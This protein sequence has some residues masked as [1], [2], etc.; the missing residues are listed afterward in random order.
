MNS[1]KMT[2][3][4]QPIT[5]ET[6]IAEYK[7]GNTTTAIFSNGTKI[8]SYEGTPI[9]DHPESIDVKITNYCDLNCAFCHEKSN[10]EGQHADLDRLLEVLSELPK[11]VELAIGGGNPLDHPDLVRFLIRVSLS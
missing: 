1:T 7:N 2:P 3:I 5:K 6:K 11:G 8:R 4:M 9:Y 10:L